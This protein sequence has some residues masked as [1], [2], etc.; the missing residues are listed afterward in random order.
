MLLPR[1]SVLRTRLAWVGL[2]I[3]GSTKKWYLP[4]GEAGAMRSGRTGGFEAELDSTGGVDATGAD[5]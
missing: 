3:L 2:E 1:I 4:A 5:Q